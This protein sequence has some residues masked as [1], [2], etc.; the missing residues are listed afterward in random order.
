MST[1]TN[2]NANASS[3]QNADRIKEI[4]HN[5]LPLPLESPVVTNPNEIGN[6][7]QLQPKINQKIN[8]KETTNIPKSNGQPNAT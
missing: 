5:P 6:K 2:A 3:N 8:T 1:K 7:E 4:N